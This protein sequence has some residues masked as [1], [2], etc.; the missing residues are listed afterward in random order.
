MVNIVRVAHRR[1]HT[2]VR[3][4]AVI[5]TSV[6]VHR[7]LTVLVVRVPIVTGRVLDTVT[8]LGGLKFLADPLAQ[9]DSDISQASSEPIW[10]WLLVALLAIMLAELFLSGHI[11]R[12]SLTAKRT[13]KMDPA[14]VG[15]WSD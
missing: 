7:D 15:E 3:R 13:V 10:P 2:T 12:R 5:N 4:D 11:S 1:R 14:T 8:D 9:A 6:V